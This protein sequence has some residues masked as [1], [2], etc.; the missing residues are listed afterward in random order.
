MASCSAP[1]VAAGAGDVHLRPNGT[2]DALAPLDTR[3]WAP[4]P[5]GTPVGGD[6][7]LEMWKN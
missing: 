4:S 1:G 3:W 5:T 7:A 2:R 6:A